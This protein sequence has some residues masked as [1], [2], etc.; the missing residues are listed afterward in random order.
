MAGLRSRDA[1][2]LARGHA[3]DVAQGSWLTDF[4]VPSKVHDRDRG[5]NNRSLSKT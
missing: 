2:G 4:T 5:K 1:E 3:A